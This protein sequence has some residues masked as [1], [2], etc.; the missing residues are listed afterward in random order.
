ML[1]KA[2]GFV[3]LFLV[4][5]VIIVVVEYLRRPTYEASVQIEIDDKREKKGRPGPRP[6]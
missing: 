3:A 6:D 2:I 1:L 5:V 4:L